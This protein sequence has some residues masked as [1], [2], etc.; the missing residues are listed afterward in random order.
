MTIREVGEEIT[1]SKTEFR[2]DKI[3]S[4]KDDKIALFNLPE[5][6]YIESIA[7]EVNIYVAWVASPCAMTLTELNV[8][9][10]PLEFFAAIVYISLT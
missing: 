8:R 6:D 5:I 9:I 10:A 2:I 4:K 1:N 3:P 7:G